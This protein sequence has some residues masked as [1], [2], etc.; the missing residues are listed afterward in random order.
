MA[1]LFGHKHD[2]LRG[3]EPD[4]ND[5]D[6]SDDDFLDVDASDFKAPRFLAFSLNGR[7]PPSQRKAIGLPRSSNATIHFCENC[8]TEYVQWVGRCSTC[9]QWNTLRSH[10]VPRRSAD[11]ISREMDRKPL[12][13][14]DEEGFEFDLFSNERLKITPEL[15]TESGNE[16]WNFDALEYIEMENTDAVEGR[17]MT[18]SGMKPVVVNALVVAGSGLRRAEGVNLARLCR[19]LA[20]LQKKFGIDFRQ[21]DV[22][23]ECAD[24]VERSADL[25]LV[26]AIISSLSSV[27]VRTDS[28]LLGEIDL[29]GN[30]QPAA[31]N[32]ELSCFSRII[33]GV[34]NGE[35]EG[36]VDRVICRTISDALDQVLLRNSPSP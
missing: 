9:R 1:A 23:V 13:A 18:I 32:H 17:A 34:V 6:D 25:A 5:D 22:Y 26:A 2:S 20:I 8:G 16:H 19:T 12:N 7:S 27:P 10:S 15:E 21:Y 11:E 31:E 4:P 30:I 24:Q 29:L 28:F 33:C 14:Q 36:Q 35:Q 3:E